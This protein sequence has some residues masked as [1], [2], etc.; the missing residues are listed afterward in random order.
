[1]LNLE[2]TARY[3]NSILGSVTSMAQAVERLEKFTFSLI[4]LSIERGI[5]YE[6]IRAAM[7]QLATENDLEVFWGA[8]PRPEPAEETAPGGEERESPTPPPE[9]AAGPQPVVSADMGIE[10][11]DRTVEQTAVVHADG[12]VEFGGDESASNDSPFQQNRGHGEKDA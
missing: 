3:L 4:K 11:S 6:E 9:A 2:T 1:M 12:N 7:D 10:G 5:S 8:K